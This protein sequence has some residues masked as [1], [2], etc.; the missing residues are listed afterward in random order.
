MVTLSLLATMHR[1]AGKGTGWFL[2]VI[3]P[4]IIMGLLVVALPLVALL[5]T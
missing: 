2:T 1:L 5:L 4:A 3:L